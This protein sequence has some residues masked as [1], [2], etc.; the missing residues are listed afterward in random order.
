MTKKLKDQ[1]DGIDSAI[2]VLV[3]RA[4]AHYEE[5]ASTQEAPHG[6]LEEE[7]LACI[8]DLKALKTRIKRQ[9]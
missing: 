8:E 7:V 4:E 6:D 5:Y 1:L 9:K 2:Q 3:A